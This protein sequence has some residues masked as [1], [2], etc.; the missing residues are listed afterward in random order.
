[1]AGK[2]KMGEPEL[3]QRLIEFDR[4]VALIHPGRSYHLVLAG[5]GALLLLGHLSRVTEDMDA[6]KC[7]PELVALMQDYDINNRVSGAYGDHFPYNWEDRLVPLDVETKVVECY[8]VSLEDLVA[9]KLCSE[10][11]IDAFD[12]RRPE[13]VMAVNWDLLAEVASEMEMSQLNPRRYGDL[14]RDF[15]AYK[16]ECRPCEG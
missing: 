10:R 16:E 4:A 8:A 5:G 15:E 13:I 11:P 6:L 14:V 1:M 7:S 9:S 2:I 3:R 12:V